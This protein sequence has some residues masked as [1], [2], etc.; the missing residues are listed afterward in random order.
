MTTIAQEARYPIVFGYEVPSRVHNIVEGSWYHLLIF[1]HHL[2]DLSIDH[3]L[4]RQQSQ[5]Q[6]PPCKGIQYGKAQLTKNI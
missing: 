4:T 1:L 5:H 2:R 6:Y 3:K